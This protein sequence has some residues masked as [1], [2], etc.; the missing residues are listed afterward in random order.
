MPGSPRSF[1]PCLDRRDGGRRAPSRNSWALM[2]ILTALALFCGC[3]WFCSRVRTS[4]DTEAQ[5]SPRPV[6]LPSHEVAAVKGRGIVAVQPSRGDPVVAVQIWSARGSGDE[7]DAT[8]GLASLCAEVFCQRARPPAGLSVTGWASPDATVC[9]IMGP[10]ELAADATEHAA[11]LLSPTLEGEG[12]DGREVCRSLE[13]RWRRTRDEARRVLTEALFRAMFRERPYATPVFSSSSCER[14]TVGTNEVCEDWFLEGAITVSAAGGD[15][16]ASG[17]ARELA[18]Q[19]WRPQAE[20]PRAARS[21]LAEREPRITVERATGPL[22]H[23]SVAFELPRLE[24]TQLASLELLNVA[25]TRGPSSRLLRS[26]ASLSGQI[27]APSGYLF[28]GRRAGALVLSASAEPDDIGEAARSLLAVSLSLHTNPL[29]GSELERARSLAQLAHAKARS[30]AAGAARDLGFHTV[31][32]G[33]PGRGA[34]VHN[35]LAE[36]RLSD[37]EEAASELLLPERMTVAA[38]LPEHLERQ[39]TKNLPID[40]DEGSPRVSDGRLRALLAGI[41]G[42]VSSAYF[43]NV[44]VDDGD[45]VTRIRL[46][47]GPLLLIHREREAT[48]VAIRASCPLNGA[49]HSINA[50]GELSL[51][52]GLIARRRDEHPTARHLLAQA[53]RDALTVADEVLPHQLETGL[54]ELMEGILQ[55]DITEEALDDV[56]SVLTSWSAEI[57]DDP[58]YLGQLALR[59]ALHRGTPYQIMF[60]GSI[61][62]IDATDLERLRSLHSDVVRPD[63][64][65]ITVVGP[66]SAARVRRAISAIFAVAPRP[67]EDRRAPAEASW[68]SRQPMAEEIRRIVG[69]ERVHLRLG[70][71]ADGLS[72]PTWPRTAVLVELLAAADGP[73]IERLES[74]GLSSRCWVSSWHGA[75]RGELVLHVVTALENEARVL[76]VLGQVVGDLRTIPPSRE[77]VERSSRAAA[78]RLAVRLASPAGRCDALD[79]AAMAGLAPTELLEARQRILDVDPDELH[80]T[81]RGTFSEHR[82]ILVVTGP[83]AAADAPAAD[84]D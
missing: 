16:S 30:T 50:A 4:S 75:R 39:P 43:E 61:Q 26:P 84:S 34:A 32:G 1:M 35:A 2:S 6:P 15:I 31:T 33:D 68:S 12:P 62:A 53:S 19:G 71:T 73:F 67:E 57:G 42:E 37:V 8:R 24:E 58:D 11:R 60:P 41:V 29:T 38:V 23:L 79:A 44:E 54:V 36:V 40:I 51:L 17:L 45:E 47:D 27:Q 63:R 10:S 7:D 83:A 18:Q 3:G 25:L 22:A 80:D 65:V 74:Q 46:E 69:G 14:P 9:E 5:P 52:N 82:G 21:S 49:W 78:R 66:V 20:L 72:V 70:F 28:I 64:M 55:P 76:E 59:E 77:S 48:T 56:R 81:A 13:E